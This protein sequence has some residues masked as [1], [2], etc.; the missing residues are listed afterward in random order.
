[1]KK[2]E[3]ALKGRVLARVHADDLRKVAGRN[4]KNVP[5]NGIRD[6]EVVTD[7][8]WALADHEV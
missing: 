2:N 3:D 8:T 7:P 1:M 6:V 5:T 4:T